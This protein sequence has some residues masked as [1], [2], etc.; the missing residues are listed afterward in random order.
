MH[1]LTGEKLAIK[2][3]E[4]SKISDTGDVERISRELLILKLLRHPNII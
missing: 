3:L 1:I 2:I 4:K